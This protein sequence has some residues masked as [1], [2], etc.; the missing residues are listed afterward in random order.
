MIVRTHRERKELYIKALEEEVLRLKETFSQASKS[1]EALAEENRRLKQLLAEHGIPWNGI[2]G[3]EEYARTSSNSYT[4]GGS[5]NG[6]NTTPSTAYSP[7]SS[8]NNYGGSNSNQGING[9][10]Y[11]ATQQQSQ[12]NVDHDQA[13]I[14]FVLTYAP[15]PHRA[16]LS[17]PPQ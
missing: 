10:S 2:G 17:P 11:Q 9:A 1:K 13:G 4:S 5:T 16:Y 6:S 7:P 3:L 14:D 15:N 12:P 8:G